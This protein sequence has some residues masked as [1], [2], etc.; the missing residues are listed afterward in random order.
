MFFGLSER[1]TNQCREQQRCRPYHAGLLA[2]VGQYAACPLAAFGSLLFSC[3]LGGSARRGEHCGDYVSANILF[4]VEDYGKAGLG[5]LK[6]VSAVAGYIRLCEGHRRGTNVSMP[7]SHLYELHG[8]E[9]SSAG[10]RNSS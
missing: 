3:S 1:T 10:S 7:S 6:P 5:T 8:G 2:I 4:H 9:T